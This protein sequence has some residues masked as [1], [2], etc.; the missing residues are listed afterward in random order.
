MTSE[1][2]TFGELESGVRSYCRKFP[3]VFAKAVGSHLYDNAGHAYIDFLSCAGAVNYGHNHPVLKR[4]LCDYLMADGIQAALDFHTNAKLAFLTTFRDKILK[5]RDL[6]YRLQFTGPTGTSVVESAIKLARK[7]TGRNNVVAFT[8]GFHG[9]SATSLG[10]TGNSY[11]RQRV[12]DPY[13]TRMPF[14]GYFDEGVDGLAL[15][16]KMLSDKSSGLDLPAAIIVETIQG[17]GGVNIASSAWLL[18]LEKLARQHGILLIVDDIQA[19]CGRTGRFFSFEFAGIQPD[20]VCL[21]KSLSGYGLPMS[22]LLI[23]PRHDQWSPAEDNGTF[24]GNTMAFVTAATALQEFWSDSALE[25]H[26]EHAERQVLASL[27][28]L[29]QSRPDLIRAA[30]GRGLFYGLEFF[31][32]EVAAAVATECFRQRLIIERCGSEDQVIKLFPALNI[33]LEVLQR[34]LDILSKAVLDCLPG[35][36]ESTPH[37][38]RCA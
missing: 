24:R 21:S 20:L 2:E 35:R 12:Q 13:V 22:V 9:M 15:F 4:A 32:P 38:L 37:E 31:D 27:T 34:G 16:E 3:S 14:D 25:L 6:D 28:R 17:E 18:R 33:E 23:A 29:S 11:H 19:G 1:I 10:L 26:I 8:N 30:R 36:A 5:P 7:V